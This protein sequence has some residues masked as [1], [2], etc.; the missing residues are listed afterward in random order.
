MS[1]TGERHVSIGRLCKNDM[2]KKIRLNTQLIIIFEI[3]RQFDDK[4]RFVFFSTSIKLNGEKTWNARKKAIFFTA[5]K[6]DL[7]KVNFRMNFALISWRSMLNHINYYW[8]RKMDPIF[9]SYNDI[10]SRGKCREKALMT[11]AKNWIVERL[12]VDTEKS[13]SKFNTLD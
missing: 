12:A 11:G 5:N 8:V 4:K 3:A 10:T 13:H 1:Q 2:R 7:N 9:R 6:F